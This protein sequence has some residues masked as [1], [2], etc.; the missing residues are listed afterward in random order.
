M[1]NWV[2]GTLR[3][4]I[5]HPCILQRD[6]ASETPHLCPG[7]P[8]PIITLRPRQNGC[9][10]ADDPFKDIFLNETLRISIKMSLN[11]VPKGPINDI[12]AMVQIMAWRRRGDKPLSEPMMISLH[13]H[14]YMRHLASMIYMRGGCADKRAP[15]TYFC[16]A[17]VRSESQQHNRKWKMLSKELRSH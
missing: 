3:F 4:Q 2:T 16:P 13:T 1:A 17:A 5:H 9:H 11:F 7:Y 8:Y 10:F 6:V 15:I 14:I 12:P